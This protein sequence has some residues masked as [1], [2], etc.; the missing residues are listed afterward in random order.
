MKDVTVVHV[1]A[2]FF[3]NKWIGAILKKIFLVA[4]HVLIFG[5]VTWENFQVL[6][7]VQSNI[8]WFFKCKPCVNC[9]VMSL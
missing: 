5:F 6:L 2:P 7:N 8:K 9:S 1:L 4:M 3:F